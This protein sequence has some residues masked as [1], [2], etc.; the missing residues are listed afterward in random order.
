MG[1]IGKAA[2]ALRSENLLRR[3]EVVTNFMGGDSYK[4]NPLDTLK[5]IT[6]SSIF[7]EPSYY[8]DG[9]LGVRV[10]DEKYNVHPLLRDFS[11]LNDESGKTTTEIME[12]AIDAALDY[13]FDGVLEWAKELRLHYNMR[14]NPQ[15][16]MVRAAVHPKRKEYTDSHKG[17]FGEVEQIVMR[18]ADEP[19]SQIDRKSVV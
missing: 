11:M 6:A 4:V 10:V 17:K 16:I 7:A 18:R 15:V 3:D 8:R 5:L 1:K 12:D 14:L 9:G 19:M 2:N 13:D